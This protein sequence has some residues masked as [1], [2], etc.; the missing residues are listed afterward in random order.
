MQTRSSESRDRIR[1]DTLLN[2][3]SELIKKVPTSSQNV[4]SC[5]AAYVKLVDYRRILSSYAENLQ[6]ASTD[7]SGDLSS[8]ENADRHCISAGETLFQAIP[9][10]HPLK[11]RAV[12]LHLEHV[13]LPKADGDQ[14]GS[15]VYQ[16]ASCRKPKI[17]EF[18]GRKSSW[19][20]W[21]TMFETE[22]HQR[23]DLS[24]ASKF[25]YLLSSIK[26]NTLAY[27]LVTVYAGIVGAYDR[28]WK[29]LTDHHRQVSDLENVHFL[30]LKDLS[31]KYKVENSEDVRR[32]EILFRSSW[33]HVSALEAVGATPA[34]FQLLALLSIKECLPSALR[35][36]YFLERGSEETVEQRLEAMF[37]FLR[38]EIE[39][40]QKASELNKNEPTSSKQV[41]GGKKFAFRY[42]KNTRNKPKYSSMVQEDSE[43]Q[44]SKTSDNLN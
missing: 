15:D 30:A 8:F 41:D 43:V 3:C 7:L 40:R 39:A 18:D 44:E 2:L 34:S 12:P 11:T 33:G 37:V 38:Q 35:V 14:K 17:E 42:K 23:A 36:K 6:S 24:S 4:G 9:P 27:R 1:R 29:D 5:V 20:V 26:K 16:N 22:V 10:E 21:K 13:L 25:A 28:A 19:V 32:L 31:K